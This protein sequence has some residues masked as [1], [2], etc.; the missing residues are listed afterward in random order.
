MSKENEGNKFRSTDK[1]MIRTKRT[2]FQ[3]IF[4]N[5]FVKTVLHCK[6]AGGWEK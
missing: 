3:F 5:C 2:Y 4:M 6:F 1:I